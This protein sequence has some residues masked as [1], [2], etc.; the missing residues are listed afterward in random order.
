MRTSILVLISCAAFAGCASVNRTVDKGT[1]AIG[2]LLLPVPEEVQLGNQLAAEVN[3]QEKIL[4]DPQ[5]Q[6]YVNSVGQKVVQASGDKRDGIKYS[7]TVIDQPGTINAFALPG[8][9]IYVYSGL[10]LAARSE[11]ELAGVLAH[12]VGHVTSRHAAQALGTAYGLQT[13]SAIA[14]GQ[15]PGALQQLAAGIAAQG[16]MARHSRDAER[17]ADMKGLQYMT[18]AGYDPKAMPRFFEELVRISGKSNAVSE[19]FASHPNPQERVK[20]LNAEIAKKGNPTGKS[21]IVGGFDQVQAR[22]KG[23][24]APSSAPPSG[25]TPPPSSGGAPA[26]GGGAPAPPPAPAPAPAPGKK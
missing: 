9:H 1:G 8:G 20:N 17:E 19:F 23:G 18:K 26:P 21:S 6:A 7:F 14:L 22:L 2:E 11:A 13:L 10:I 12:E 5:V 24:K 4:Q 15:N 16:Y 25:G 3:Q